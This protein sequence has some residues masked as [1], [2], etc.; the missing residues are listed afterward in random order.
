MMIIEPLNSD[1]ESHI[2]E[3][4]SDPC[5]LIRQLYNLHGT[6]WRYMKHGYDIIEIEPYKFKVTFN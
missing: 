6:C 1:L 3:E 4:L 2:I 5:D